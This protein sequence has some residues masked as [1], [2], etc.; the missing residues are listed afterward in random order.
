MTSAFRQQLD[1]QLHYQRSALLAALAGLSGAALERY[2]WAD[3]TPRG[4]LPHIA[5][6]E[7][8]ETQRLRAALDGRWNAPVLQE[9]IDTDTQNAAWHAQDAA[10]PLATGVAMLLKERNGLLNVLTEMPDAV[11]QATVKV[12]ADV[13]IPVL[14]ALNNCIEHDEEHADDLW[15]WRQANGMADDVAGPTDVL[16]A[17]LRAERKA[18]AAAL[19]LRG[20]PP[21]AALLA[22]LLGSDDAAAGEHALAQLAAQQNAAIA[23]AADAVAYLPLLA[24]LRARLP[25]IDRHYGAWLVARRT[26]GAAA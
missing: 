22:A 19:A 5:R 6:W 14:E 18:V 26:R 1:F 16:M 17:A 3:W 21:P 20:G 12:A 15:R 13:E 8:L 25:L 2:L 7:A 11:L 9:M 10:T 4:L 23:Q 24:A